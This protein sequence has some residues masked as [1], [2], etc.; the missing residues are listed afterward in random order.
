MTVILTIAYFA[1]LI[2]GA[3]KIGDNAAGRG[4]AL[5]ILGTLAFVAFKDGPE[6]LLRGSE[7]YTDWDGRSNPTVC[8]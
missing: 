2:W 4:I 6:A 3:Y 7:C 1:V 5:F 8:D